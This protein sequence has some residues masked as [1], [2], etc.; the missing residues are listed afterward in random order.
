MKSLNEETSLGEQI[1]S[2]QAE[3]EIMQ[4]VVEESASALSKKEPRKS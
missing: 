3:L 4:Q 1:E 2:S